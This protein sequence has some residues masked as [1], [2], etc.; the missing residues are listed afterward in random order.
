MYQVSE[1]YPVIFNQLNTNDYGVL[2]VQ[3][4]TQFAGDK[5][6]VDYPQSVF[7]TLQKDDQL[8]YSV[9]ADYMPAIKRH[10]VAANLAQLMPEQ[11]NGDYK[12]FLH[13]QDPRA[14]N[15]FSRELGT[16]QINF[17]EGATETTNHGVRDDYKLLDKITNYFPPEEPPKGAAI[18][19]AFT[20]VIIGLFLY[21]V[22]QLYSNHANLSNMSFW[23]LV[24]ALNYLAILAVIVAFWVKVNLVNTLWI[25]LA[26]APATL[27]TMNKGLTPDNCHISGFSRPQK[28]KTY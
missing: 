17:N 7:V 4:D 1:G 3:I 6:K 12:L 14:I 19:L 27:F 28:S 22:T 11:I 24:F 26:A 8:P 10:Q 16:L 21:F 5:D 18:P 25:L 15:T 23:G 9:H 20:V 2:H 13:V